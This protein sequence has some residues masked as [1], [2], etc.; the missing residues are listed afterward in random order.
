MVVLRRTVKVSRRR[1]A[2]F[3]LLGRLMRSSLW[4]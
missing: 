3:E 4:W 1:D 2:G